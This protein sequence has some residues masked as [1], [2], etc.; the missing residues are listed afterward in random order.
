M[1]VWQSTLLFV[2]RHPLAVA[3]GAGLLAT[4]LDLFSTAYAIGQPGIAEANPVIAHGITIGWYYVFIQ[5]LAGL[6][7]SM[8]AGRLILKLIADWRGRLVPA[9]HSLLAFPA[10]LYLVFAVSNVRLG[11]IAAGAI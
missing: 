6:G 2:R 3:C 11:L 10:L 9:L 1:K 4:T 7:M 8:M 5:K